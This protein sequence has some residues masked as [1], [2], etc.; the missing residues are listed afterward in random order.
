MPAGKTGCESAAFS[1]RR[2]RIDSLPLGTHV[3]V[4][5]TGGRIAE[6]QFVIESRRD[7]RLVQVSYVTWER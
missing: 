1:K 2:V 6:L 5:T 3:C 7:F 4:R